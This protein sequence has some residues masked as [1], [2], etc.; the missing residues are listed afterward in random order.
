MQFEEMNSAIPKAQGL[1]DPAY[2]KDSCGVG[3]IAN[4]K[5]KSSRSIV[6]KGIR[7]MCNLEHRGA[8]GADP[9]TGD[10]AG[11][12]IQV[13]HK[14][15][16]NNV[17]FPLPEQ[18]DYAVGVLFLPQDQIVREGI[19]NIIEKTIVDEGEIF[20]G[21][22]DVPVN[23]DVTG[24]VAR[25]T[26]PVFKQVFIGRSEQVEAGDPF[27]R[28][29]FLIRRVIDR[30]IRSEYKI[31]RSQYYVPSFSSR[32]IVYK[33]MLLGQQ[34][35]LFYKDLQSPDIES[36]FCLTHTRFSTNTFPT[37]DLA[38]P[39]RMIAHNGEINTLRGNMNWMAARQ[40]VMH[41]PFYGP[42]L[43][44]ML[45]I[46]LEGQSD[47]ASFDTVLELLFLGGRSVPH[48]MMMMIPEAWSKKPD[49]DPDVRAFYEYHA[50]L[51][52][53][54]DGPAAIA[55]CNGKV[56][57][58]TLDRN[59][60]RPARYV[61]TKDD[62]IIMS[63]EAG[64]LNTEP[65]NI[66]KLDRL[67][68]GRMLLVDLVKGELIDDEQIKKKISTQKPYLEWIEEKLLRLNQLP[69]PE[70]VTQP[71]HNTILERMKVFGYTSEDVTTLMTPMAVQGQEPV[72]SMGTD[73]SLPILS[74]RPQPLYRYFKQNFAQ[75][76][77]PPIDPIREELVMELTTYIGPEGNL[78]TE[79]PEHCHRIELEHPILTNKNFEK[80]KQISQGHFKT[81]TFEILFDPNVK[82]DMRNSL[83]QVCQKAEDAIRDGYNLIILTDRGVSKDRAPIPALLAVS[84][85]HHYL[86]REG[87]RTKTGIVLESGEP[88]EIVHYALLC[89]YGANAINPYL[90]F[91]TLADLFQEGLLPEVE[92][93]KTAEKNY[94]KASGKGLFK[95]FSKMGISTLQSYCGAQIFEAVG[96]DSELVN[97]YFTGTATRIEGLSLKMLEE[98]SVRR[99]KNAY[100]PSRP[101]E[102]LDTGGLH[103][104][105]KNGDPHLFNPM[106]IHK[107]QR[108]TQ[109]NDYTTYKEFSKLID[110]EY[111][112]YI[113]LRSLFK[114]DNSKAIPIPIEDVEPIGEIMRRFQTGAMSF[115]SISWEAHT[116]MAI[117][118]NQIGAKS[119]TGEG[120]ED[121]IRYKSLM[122]G[123]SMRSAIKQVASGRFGVTT[124]YLVNSDDIQ[125]KMAQGAK[126]GEGGQL[127]G[128]K[129]D[130]NIGRL[131]FS[132]PG[133]SLISPPP[134]HDIYSI[135]DL[136]Q[137][138]FD[139][140][141][142]N[143]LA[144]ISVKLVSEVGVGTVAAGVAKAHADHIL[145]SGHDGGTGASPMSSIHYAGT[146]WEIGLAETH[147]TLVIN[148][149]RDRVYLAVDGK[150]VTGKD[151]VVAALLGAEEFGFSTSALITLGCIMMRKCH[152]N[153][154]PVGI[155]TQ[156]Q[157]LRKK[158]MG[159]PEY[160]INYVRFVAEEVREYMAQLGFR[161]FKEMIG[162]V[163]RI[164]FD[165]PHHHWKARGL[166]FAKVLSKPTPAHFQTDLYRTKGQNHDLEKQ[167][168][169]E[170][171][172]RS[173]AAIDYK[174]QVKFE[175]RVTNLNRTIGAMLSGEIAKKYGEV[176]LP[177]DTIDITMRGTA[178]QSFGAFLVRGITFRLIGDT[179][180]YV[181]K[182]LC[183]GTLIVK[184]PEKATFEPTQN[185]IIGNTCFYGATRGMAFINGVAGERFCVRNSGAKVVVEG[186]G[187]HGC[188]YMT[189][190]L[191]I[192]L[193]K[194]G[195]NF[196]AGMSGGIAY[197]WD[198]DSSFKE[199]VNMQMVELEKLNN[200][201]ESEI[202]HFIRLHQEHTSSK[203]AEEILNNWGQEVKRFLK[204]M[205]IE[206]KKALLK[207]KEEEQQQANME[208]A[209]GVT[210]H[211]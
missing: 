35:K 30:R 146:P 142:V 208:I 125:I 21:F 81:I 88:R 63:S 165:R 121:D 27:E 69:E 49:M 209:K 33:G 135:E 112:Q 102:S 2:E 173:R 43:K 76:T 23:I 19:E 123:D 54:W 199:N 166:D 86:I 134:H 195:R 82:H 118:M 164:K 48:A 12:M 52:E 203:R 137:L 179:N 41:T 78:L 138:I 210:V 79:S 114:L 182:G 92:D 172:R 119:N 162:Q 186:I 120:G 189:G 80:I 83:D 157:L 96:L 7:L 93:Y 46:I 57:G 65:E 126:P 136:K 167:L 77:N 131:R 62:E 66:V 25:K 198:E 99:H 204:V 183:G 153:T 5:A 84:G 28:K 174:Q 129:V 140:K 141:N 98:E 20:L 38:H 26:I 194:T 187:D 32:T 180:D 184:V 4:I 188:E 14:F 127:P 175:I 200:P 39:Y 91:E 42:E 181:G 3:F 34:V 55:F 109:E 24:L 154:C 73:V 176:G 17:D 50:N 97:N 59:G 155:A 147:Q 15:F 6:D 171:I 40:M 168:D 70:N 51:M 122:N 1:Y 13:P 178:G 191:A 105:R 60:L 160:L 207:Q 152:L 22:R 113:T 56:I 145:I 201:E 58:A 133:V 151:V 107:L 177:D 16:K 89:G 156:N 100:D 31:D 94:I 9:K 71:D 163:D 111:D 75:V 205:P 128:H 143:P 139:L 11:I 170:I 211:G 36:S 72:A 159:K 132:T 29:L 64:V 18:G 90:A 68:P 117:A 190:G 44:R 87:L 8:E 110:Q 185:I 67:K 158:F 104:Y 85:L 196:G 193:G 103:Y 202:Y 161:T 149:L 108:S 74:D 61:I 37:W 169:N 116:S 106:T 115:G 47:T 197:V 148:G 101:G 124:N 10:G 144:R 130:K 192:I 206:Y 45:P 95:I 53:P 150:I